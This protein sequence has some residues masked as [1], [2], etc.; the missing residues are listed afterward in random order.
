MAMFETIASKTPEKL[1]LV[2]RCGTLSYAGLNERANQLA[3]HLRSLGIGLEC[4]V[5]VA[6]ERGIQYVVA[7]L[8]SWKIGATYLPL[9]QSLPAKRME[10]MM[11]DSGAS[12]LITV[13]KIIEEKSLTSKAGTTLCLDEGGLINRL[14]AY[15]STNI[16]SV[17]YHDN[18]AYIIYTS[19]TTGNP[20]GVAITHRSVFNLIDDIR[21]SH[22]IE[23]SDRVL[24]FSPFCFDASIRDINGALMLGASLYVPE[25][26]QI[27]PGNLVKTIAQHGITNSVITPSVLRSCT[28]EHL[29]DFKIIVLAGEAADA[30]LIRTWGAGR[31]L[32]NAYGPTEATVCSTKRVYYDGQIPLG[33]SASVIGRPI[34]NTTISILSDDN[35]PVQHGEVGEICITGPGVSRPGYLNMPQLNAERFRDGSFCQ[36]HSYKT[37]DLGRILPN[38]EV[39]CLGRKTCTRQIKLN[40]QRIEPEE[41]ENVIRSDFNILDVAVIPQAVAPT[42]S[43]C[44]YVVPAHESSKINT[45]ALTAHLKELMRENLPSYSIPTIIEVIDALPLTVNKKL[46]VK[47]LSET[48][49]K[50][51]RSSQSSR[52]T[53]LIP[54]EKDIAAAIL[55]ALDLPTEQTVSPGT[56]YGELG[57]SSLQASLV[58]RH[59]NRSIGCKIQLGQFYRR[60]IS[61]RHLASLISG[62]QQRQASPTPDDLLSRIIL[63]HDIVY[64]VRAPRCRR[65][66]H[67]L[68]TG[69]TG[70]LGSHLLA[71]MLSTGHTRISCIVRAPD[72]KTAWNRIKA[73]L[74]SWDLWED[75]FG[76]RF[77]VFC[78]DVCKPFLGLN[79]N[80]YLDLARKVDTIYHSAATVSFI[81]PFAELEEANVTG[82]VEI[83]R[84]AST[85]IHKRLTYIST[86]SVFF[87]VGNEA[88]CGMEVPVNI[89]Q[90]GI[91]TGYAQ[92][93]WVSEQLVLEYA[94]LG[95]HAL[96]LRPGRLL[97]STWSYKCPRDD[98][99]IRLIASILELGIAPDFDDIGGKDWQIDLTP[100]DFCA[101]LVH[102]LSMQR[103][104]GIRHIINK[105][106][107]SFEAI[108]DFLGEHVQRIPYRQ[109]L[110]LVTQSAH[111]APLSSLFHEPVS[112]QDRR[113]VFEVLLQMKVFRSSSYEATASKADPYQLPSTIQLLRKYL[114]RNLDIFPNT[115]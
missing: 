42:R 95:G 43:L 58:L 79:T 101:R 65:Q 49:F 23:P 47:A 15:S 48:T 33:R 64:N 10:Y 13:K 39:E 96:V 110:Q 12:C 27:L 18:L 108:V 113:S 20:K 77:H 8:A 32:I 98:F 80:E 70:F 25:E 87:D 94:R 111:L 99:T 29:P 76:S 36:C 38:G 54:L 63:P 100:V 78:G 51:D 109:W 73:A 17:A 11:S 31:R 4:V 24:L 35:T 89:L 66:K 61:I 74:Q 14:R 72:T 88:G 5:A 6:L 41:V 107:I 104:T 68:L 103:E 7:M 45:E 46:D 91:V 57:G 37:G 3:R 106:T 62:E 85:L 44:A 67:V 75:S 16:P 56:T 102:R 22:E 90:S 97:G 81:A 60:D 50:T 86:L 53:L 26:E 59:L 9:D 21:Q 19:G 28:L 92:S 55:K 84:F 52:E 40:G 105:S 112:D 114:K 82:T 69:S 2:S 1:A 34:L 115:K 93:K 71:E 83:L 30:T